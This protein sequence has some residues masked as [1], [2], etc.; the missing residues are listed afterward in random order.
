MNLE[1]GL[2]AKDELHLKKFCK[3]IGIGEGNIHKKINHLNATDK[4]Y[5][6]VDV[7]IFST[8][9]CRA[10]IAH[11]ITPRKSEILLFPTTVPADLLIHYLRGY[12]DGDGSLGICSQCI[13]VCQLRIMATLPFI[14]GIQSNFNIEKII[15]RRHSETTNVYSLTINSKDSLRLIK[16][17]YCCAS[18]FLT[19]KYIK[20]HEIIAQLS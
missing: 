11:G 2:S 7:K 12:V 1:I 20:A 14:K 19:R 13:N 6:V 4:N 10:L 8:K 17:M 16:Q 9:L 5:D 18:I 3:F 15:I